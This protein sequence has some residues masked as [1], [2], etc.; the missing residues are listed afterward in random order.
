MKAEEARE[1]GN[2]AFKKGDY[3]GALKLYDEGVRRDPTSA[4]I[5]SNRAFAYIKLMRFN[6]ALDDC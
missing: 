5:Y 3:P 1:A 6:E 2:E 4:K